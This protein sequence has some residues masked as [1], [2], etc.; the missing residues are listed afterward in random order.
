M[1]QLILMQKKILIQMMKIQKTLRVQ[2]L[3]HHN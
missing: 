3:K 1:K 2:Y